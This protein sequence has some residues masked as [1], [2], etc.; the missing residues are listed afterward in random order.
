[1]SFVPRAKTLNKSEL[2][3]VALAATLAVLTVLSGGPAQATRMSPQIAKEAKTIFGADLKFRLDGA[4]ETKGGDLFLPIL[5]RNYSSKDYAPGKVLGLIQG[6]NKDLE[7]VVFESGVCFLK[8]LKKPGFRTL[9]PLS[10]MDDKLKKIV[11]SGHLAADLI[12]PE[13]FVLGPEFKPIVGDLSIT[14]SGDR[15]ESMSGGAAASTATGAHHGV[16]KSLGGIYVTSPASGSVI[17]IDEKSMKKSTEF[18]T[19]GTP[20]GMTMVDHYLYIADQSKSRVLVLDTAERKWAGQID[21]QPKS[22]P[23]AV[24]LM[25]GGKLLYVTESG[26][27]LVD[28]I[29]VA[30]GKVLMRTKV[31]P[32]PSRIAISPNGNTV[33]VLN[34]P[35]GQVSFISTLNQKLISTLNVGASP[36]CVVVSADSRTAYVSCK[37][38]NYVMIVDTIKRI[39]LGVLKCANGPTGLALSADGAHLYVASAK[40]NM[41]QVFDTGTKAAVHEY[42]LPMDVDFPGVI[43][44]SPDG[45]KLFVSSAAT[46]TLGI[47]NVENGEFSQVPIGKRSDEI[48][49]VH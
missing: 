41:I 7:A 34:V 2:L 1:M 20:A 46:D 33:L 24:A 38:A 13:E 25:P 12:V 16:K 22:A 18:P 32:G 42:K 28:C 29:E 4:V 36:Q 47:M 14:I 19:E 31:P 10:L 15:H 35:T 39:P 5:P 30:T 23:K 45:K 27:G 8:V 37:S 3:K 21:L 44:L 26:T 40:D 17:L 11:V 48:V 43:T 6:K 9:P 49:Y